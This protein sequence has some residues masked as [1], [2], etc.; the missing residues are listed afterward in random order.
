MK[1]KIIFIAGLM[2]IC[3][4]TFAQDSPSERVKSL[5]V[6]FITTELNLS[7]A[8]SEKFWPVYNSYEAKQFKL[9]NQVMKNVR[10][11]IERGVDN[12]PEKEA[13]KLLA[14]MQQT[15]NDLHQ[16]RVQFLNDLKKIISPVKILKLK[17]AEDDFNRKLLKQY[18]GKR[19]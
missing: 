5:K 2:L 17:K 11:K 9:R 1:L 13:A 15:E 16:N 19:K 14:D 8:E 4:L 10:Q 6:A 7:T 3:T 12:L 18:R